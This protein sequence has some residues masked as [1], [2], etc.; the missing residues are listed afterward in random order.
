MTKPQPASTPSRVNL[1]MALLP[2]LLLVAL[3]A[4]FLW[5]NPLAFF[6]GAFPPLEELS[7]QQVRFPTEG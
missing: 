2:L 5:L 6:T 3:V 1:V 4:A 7:I